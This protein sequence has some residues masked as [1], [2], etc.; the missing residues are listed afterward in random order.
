VRSARERR[1]YNG[2][3]FARATI[4]GVFAALAVAA[5]AHAQPRPAS[6][7]P[8]ET[9]WTLALNSALAAP[10][11]FDGTLAYFPLQG[12]RLAAYDLTRGT[13]LWLAPVAIKTRP[14]VG[15]GLVFVDAGTRVV[16]LRQQDGAEIWS[17]VLGE[18]LTA[19]LT[20]DNGWLIAATETG[21]VRA[22]RATDGGVIWERSLDAAASAA[23]ALA[24]DR[25]YLSLQNQ[26]V[27][28]L[29]V[30]SGEVVWQRRLGGIPQEI[31]ALDDRLYV[32]VA[33][34][35]FYSLTANS[36]MVDWKWELG[37]D[38]AGL[39]ALDAS[40]IYLV[41]R[42]NVLRAMDRRTGALRWDQ[43]VPLRPVAGPLPVGDMLLVSGVG[44][45]V[46]AYAMSDGDPENEIT[47]A[48]DLVAP[49]YVIE[50]QYRPTL[51]L[52]TGS[53]DAG[54]EVHAIS[55]RIEPAPVPIK[56]LPDPVEIEPPATTTI[57]P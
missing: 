34:K 40:R 12:D 21:R 1:Y 38:T 19:S 35:I 42:D 6:L 24:A 14:A 46:R 11:R 29:H 4:C 22:H 47:A 9:R 54:A 49:P 37:G 55:R 23:P 33:G 36:G 56:P 15:D 50:D 20:W 7:F 45:S 18:P 5:G 31:L 39:P 53:L 26:T 52:V 44:T 16:A 51:I 57:A 27:T 8:A 28:A 41:S 48:G 32:G 17:H 3:R 25:V 10:P 13:L 30:A 43:A 2:V